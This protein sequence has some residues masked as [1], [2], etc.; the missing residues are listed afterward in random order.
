[1]PKS[2]PSEQ[3][4]AMTP[5]A[6]RLPLPLFVDPK[7]LPST[8][9][10]KVDV[11]ALWPVE[12]KPLVDTLPALQWQLEQA[13]RDWLRE[14]PYMRRGEYRRWRYSTCPDSAAPFMLTASDAAIGDIDLRIEAAA[15]AGDPDA[16]EYENS[17]MRRCRNDDEGTLVAPLSAAERR[18]MEKRENELY[19]AFLPKRDEL[20]WCRPFHSCHQWVRFT[21]ALAMAWEPQTEWRIAAGEYHSTVIDRAGLRVFD[22]LLIYS[23]D[24][25]DE[26]ILFAKGDPRSSSIQQ[27]REYDARA[28]SPRLL[29]TLAAYEGDPSKIL[30]TSP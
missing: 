15:E 6:T 20:I 5:T 19:T 2:K 14:Y 8:G 16:V 13:V 21:H 17:V 10:T 29:E 7:A 25:P 9:W 11:V 30:E 23:D 28:L 1:M 27:Q 24:E 4:T 22:L 18:R 12:L 26:A 3:R